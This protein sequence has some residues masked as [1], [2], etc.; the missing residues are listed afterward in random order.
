M[1]SPRSPPLLH[2][3]KCST[4]PS[5]QNAHA[6]PMLRPFLPGLHQAGKLGWLLQKALPSKPGI[7]SEPARSAEPSRCSHNSDL[8]TWLKTSRSHSPNS[9]ATHPSLLPKPRTRLA[10]WEKPWPKICTRSMDR[11]MRRLGRA[12]R[13]SWIVLVP[14]TWSH[15]LSGSDQNSP[16]R[17]FYH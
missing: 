15:F 3:P 8:Q 11:G 6:K 14:S 10:F 7:S 2:A 13:M 16:N 4:W 9:P 1:T 5:L 17:L 12:S